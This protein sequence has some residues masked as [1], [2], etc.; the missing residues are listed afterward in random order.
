MD[1]DGKKIKLL[2]T[3]TAG[4]E[5]FKSI[6]RT[7]YKNS[8]AVVLVYDIVDQRSFKEL[9]KWLVDVESNTSKD[10]LKILL[11]NKCDRL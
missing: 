2:L 1:I 11:G 10:I 3:D 8:D 6:P 4:Q 5:R 7:F 9:N